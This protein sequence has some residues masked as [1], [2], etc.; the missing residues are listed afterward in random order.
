MKHYTVES[1]GIW[2]L[3]YK[4][5]IFDEN[6]NDVCST[7]VNSCDIEGYCQCLADFGY[8][9]FIDGINHYQFI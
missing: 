9:Y 2:I 7:L 5:T 3:D 8:M 4:V 6:D 1:V